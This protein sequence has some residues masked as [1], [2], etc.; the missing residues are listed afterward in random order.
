M[1]YLIHVHRV[2]IE[3]EAPNNPLSRDSTIVV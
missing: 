2:K 3:T 1:V